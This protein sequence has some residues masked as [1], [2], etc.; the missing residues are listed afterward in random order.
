MNGSS[1]SL[2]PSRLSV[3]CGECGRYL[4]CPEVLEGRAALV[5]ALSGPKQPWIWWNSSKQAAATRCAEFDVLERSVPAQR[6]A[7]NVEYSAAVV[8][9][10]SRIPRSMF[11]STFAVSR[12]IGWSV[13][14]LEQAGAGKILLPS[15]R[16]VGPEPIRV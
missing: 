16:Y 11:T 5:V 4:D 1:L 14:V 15:A 3:P 13:H 10:L 8:L 2:D 7:T 6:I 12:S 9:L